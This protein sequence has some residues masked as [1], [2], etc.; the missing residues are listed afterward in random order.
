MC[1][2][3]VR[4]DQKGKKKKMEKSCH[5]KCFQLKLMELSF[6]DY[7]AGLAQHLNLYSI[8]IMQNAQPKLLQ[9]LN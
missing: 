2:R 7:Y 4:G 3:S 1:E 9:Q 8:N 5:K 6:M